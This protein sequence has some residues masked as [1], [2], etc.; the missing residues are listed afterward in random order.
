AP[1]TSLLYTPPLHDALP[2]CLDRLRRRSRMA[3]AA[4]HA[5]PVG[6][7]DRVQHHELPGDSAAV[8]SDPLGR[9]LRVL[10]WNRRAWGR[11]QSVSRSEE[12]TSE[13]QSPY[14]LVCRL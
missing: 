13:L 12:H 9:F 5:W 11:I 8:F 14:D 4:D 3:E 6:R 2:I 1:A 7:R 10:R